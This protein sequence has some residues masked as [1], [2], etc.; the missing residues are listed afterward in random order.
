MK[1]T[2]RK[3]LR[4]SNG[5]T[6]IALVVTIVVLLILAGVSINL[7]IG[8]NGII[9]KAGDAKTEYE[10]AAQD[11]KTGM[12]SLYDEMTNLVGENNNGGNTGNSVTIQIGGNNV[13]LTKDDFGEYLGKKV[14]NYKTPGSTETVTVGS[15]NYTVSTTYR[16]YYID[17][18]NKYGD[19]AGTVYLKADCT[20]N[21]YSLPVTDTSA[22]TEANIKIKN[23]NP[24]LYEE[25]VTPP[26]STNNNMKA[27]TWLTN[28]T[29]W[30]GLKTSGASTA[31]GNKVNY[32]VG[33][34]SLEMMMD[35]FNTHY[36]LTGDTPDYST[37]TESSP[38]TKLFYKYPYDSNN[39]GYGVG[40]NADNSVEY[41][42]YTSAYSVQTDSSID[43]MYYPGSNQYYWLAS[44][45]ANYSDIVM[46]VNY[47]YGG[48]VG[49]IPYD[50]NNAFCPLVSLKSSVSL[51]LAD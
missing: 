17:F 39:Y 2:K 44:P 3:K 7:V 43:T 5:I 42:Y 8:N 38:R 47:S 20:G 15:E 32:V 46:S 41:Q 51:E 25:G 33:T 21:N 12:N 30:E 28:T 9:T 23:L 48:I 29:N 34:P 18:D 22:D 1:E 37:R 45:S 27:V 26:T 4:K 24:A 10:Q 35:S 49:G 36:K 31:I 40:P 16:L 6:L 14:T 11:E 50:G 19:G 13:T